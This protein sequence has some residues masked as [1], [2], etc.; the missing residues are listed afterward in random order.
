MG[1][2]STRGE[3]VYRRTET[4]GAKFFMNV[5]IVQVQGTRGLE[6]LILSYDDSFTGQVYMALFKIMSCIDKNVKLTKKSA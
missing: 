1:T 5:M 2:Y 6:K 3:F 4:F